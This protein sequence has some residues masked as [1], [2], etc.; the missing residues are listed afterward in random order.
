MAARRLHPLLTSASPSGDA[1]GPV[2]LRDR[3][4][5]GT[6]NALGVA[7]SGLPT[8]GWGAAAK[9]HSPGTGSASPLVPVLLAAGWSLPFAA[10]R[11]N[12]HQ[13]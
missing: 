6:S 1:W 9:E 8:E 2:M 12:M 10:G 13:F 11:R 7:F 4:C 5:S 3:R